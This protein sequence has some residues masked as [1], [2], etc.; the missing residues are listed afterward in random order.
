MFREVH[1]LNKSRKAS[2]SSRTVRLEREIRQLYAGR[3]DGRTDASAGPVWFIT[4]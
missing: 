4:L 3:M 1:S 2:Y